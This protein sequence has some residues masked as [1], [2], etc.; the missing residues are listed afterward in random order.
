VLD[1]AIGDGECFRSCRVRYDARMR[2]EREFD[3]EPLRRLRAAKRIAFVFSGGAARCVFQVG[4]LETL[5]ELGIAPALCVAVSAGAWNGAAV[6]AGTAHRLRRYWRAF[7]RMPRFDVT[8]LVREHSPFIFPELHRRTFARYVGA[9]RLRAPGA[10]PLLVGATRLRD[11]RS[12]LFDAREA[13]DPLR[14]LLATNYLPPF[15]THAPRLAGER[16]GD[17]GLSNNLPY[18]A[19]FA[20]GCDAAV[21]LTMKGESEGGL[22]RGPREPDHVVPAALAGRVVVIRPRHRFP[23]SFTER[24]WPRLLAIVEL[25]RLRA[26]EVLLGERHPETDLRAAGRAPSALFSRFLRAEPEGIES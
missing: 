21:V 13:E 2:G 23:L 15:Y 12:V 14:L 11:R 3:S 20:A 22:Y 8:N 9:E 26:R 16:Y 18:E 19:A 7:M 10:L 4:A 17:G 25:G 24:R 1:D 5:R 6:A